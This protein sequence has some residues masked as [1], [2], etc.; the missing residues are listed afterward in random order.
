MNPMAGLALVRLHEATADRVVMLVSPGLDRDTIIR[1]GMVPY[2]EAQDALA[3]ALA[4]HGPRSRVLAL[5]YASE[6][7]PIMNRASRGEN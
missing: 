7:L 2:E 4:R 6:L 5:R 1:L 3:D